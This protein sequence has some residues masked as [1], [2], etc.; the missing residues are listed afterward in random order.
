MAGNVDMWHEYRRKS[1]AERARLFILDD[2]YCAVPPSAILPAPIEEFRMPTTR[3]CVIAFLVV[4]VLSA[5]APAQTTQPA[6]PSPRRAPNPAFAPVKDDPALPRVLLIGDSISIGYTLPTREK[7]KGKANVHRPAA[8]CGPT[9]RGLEN[10]DKWLGDSK[11][12]LIH[13]NFGLHD[14]KY[15]DDAG[16]NT[17]PDKGHQQVPPEQ[18][19]KNLEQIVQRLKK[20]GAVLIFATTT[21]V[22]SGEPQR[23]HD[24]AMK[25]NEIARRV[26]QRHDVGI[27]DLHAF[28]GQPSMKGA[29]LPADVH[30]T[31]EG[32]A[33]LGEEVAKQIEAAFPK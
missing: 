26:L 28:C 17:A 30:F 33:T 20:T 13:F 5:I 6:S 23:V 10:L 32:Y 24:E 2:P 4:L 27:D 19:E 8:N 16:K 12:D 7:L 3:S 9:T 21:P 18:Y 11:W 29:Q 31:K 22:P 14:L 15:I 1:A 25:Y